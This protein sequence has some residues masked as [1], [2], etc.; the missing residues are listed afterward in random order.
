MT[1]ILSQIGIHCKNFVDLRFEVYSI[2]TTE[3]LAIVTHVAN[4]EP[5]SLVR[6]NIDSWVCAGDFSEIVSDFDEIIFDNWKEGDM[7]D[8][9]PNAAHVITAC[10]SALKGWKSATDVG[11]TE[12]V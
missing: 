12:Q 8:A 11:L 3:A 6:C 7:G 1:E 5:L 10:T 4:I 2:T 9:I